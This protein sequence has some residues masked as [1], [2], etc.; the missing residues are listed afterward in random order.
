MR[1]PFFDPPRREIV[2]VCDDLIER[3]SLQAQDEALHLAEVAGALGS[4]RNQRIFRLAA[5]EIE[6]RISGSRTVLPRGTASA[7]L[8]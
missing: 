4:R 6:M 8:S 3:F 2:A 7:Q 1:W 5:H